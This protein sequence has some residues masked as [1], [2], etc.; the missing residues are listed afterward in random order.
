M[1]RNSFRTVLLA[2][3][4]A[5]SGLLTGISA[6][7]TP[8]PDVPPGFDPHPSAPTGWTWRPLATIAATAPEGT[9]WE[10]YAGGD[11]ARWNVLL[12]PWLGTPS[13]I[14]TSGI[15]LGQA[16]LGG[17]D[18]TVDRMRVFALRRADLLG[19]DRPDDMKLHRVS[20]TTNPSGHRIL[21]VD[22]KQTYRGYDV[23]TPTERVRVRIRADGTLG[24]VSVF[25]SDWIRRLACPIAPIP[26]GDAAARAL[27]QFPQFPPGSVRVTGLSTYVLVAPARTGETEL[28]THLVHHVTLESADPADAWSVL[29]DANDGS[30]IRKHLDTMHLP[31]DV[32]GNVAA[33]TLEGGARG[34]F[35][36]VPMR[37]LIVQVVG[38]QSASTDVNG[39]FRIPHSGTAP[40][41]VTGRFDG[42]W[43]RVENKFLS[44]TFFYLPA[45][46]GQPA[47]IVLNPVH[48]N[49]YQT[50]EATAYRF[51]TEAR[52]FIAQRVPRFTALRSLVANVNVTNGGA[53]TAWYNYSTINFVVAAKWVGWNCPN[54]AFEEAIVHEYG[55]AFHHWFHGSS[56]LPR[57]FSEG[58]ASHLALYLTGQRIM[59]RDAHNPGEHLED[60]NLPVTIPPG[61]RDRQYQ[62]PMCAGSY[63][64]Y[65]QAWVGFTL[66]LRDLML[67]KHGPVQG[68]NVAE[69]ITIAQYDRAPAS[70]PTGVLEVFVQDDNDAN[71][72]NGS[73]NFKQIAQAA[74]GHSFPRPAD[75]PYVKVTHTGLAD[76]RDTVNPY[77]VSASITAPA[78]PVNG[79]WVVYRVGSGPFTSL[80]L[81]HVSGSTYAGAIPA[82]SAVSHVAYRIVGRD[83]KNN[84]SRLP[85]IGDFTFTV[86]QRK[87]IF[88]DD[89]ETDKGWTGV[90][91]AW[92]G[93]FERADPIAFTLGVGPI[94]LAVQPEDDHSPGSGTHCYVT[95]NGDRKYNRLPD[96]YD[97]DHGYTEIRSPVFDVSSQAASAV[98]VRYA[99]WFFTFNND[100]ALTTDVSADGGQTWKNA[101]TVPTIANQWVVSEASLPGPYT[102]R[103]Q[104]RFRTE[105][106]PNDSLTDACIDDVEVV[107]FDDDVAALKG[108]SRTP[109]IGAPL[110]YTLDA[111]KRPGGVYAFALSLTPGPTPI[112]GLGNLDLGVPFYVIASGVLDA[113]GH[114]AFRIPIPNVPVLRGTR[115]YT[116]AVVFTNDAILSNP[117][118]VQIQ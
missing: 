103:M 76:T 87:R 58:I 91:T 61:A 107:A 44:N 65:G 34:A 27:E 95:Q 13:M 75:P 5:A 6:Q 46:P 20:V 39:N 80:A 109:G 41:N 22:F 32:T 25:G 98:R 17:R 84:V 54:Y 56:S 57:S 81:N 69:I 72:T 33:G 24:R 71:L 102:N 63:H 78:A 38:G 59:G 60:Y 55:H 36:V 67:L 45:T 86:G 106:D 88:F 104:V 18:A 116:E 114:A 52:Y 35:K 105:D 101:A 23:W 115:I 83:A 97:V 49:Q 100:D 12:H 21:G 93:R 64:C 110:P 90:H 50:A 70:M 10:H 40:V 77:P 89:F 82:Q 15:D 28:D 118:N 1:V 2:S 37:S 9:A 113:S 96:N 62:D 26:P 31:T 66:D 79:A 53:C 117:W 4:L 43:C 108:A 14:I 8:G 94:N 74:D 99:R 111:A 30:L 73:P 51:A 47:N 19:I 42:D 112:P 7:H 92:T 68:K 85:E 29:L 16:P 48:V 3:V 11:G